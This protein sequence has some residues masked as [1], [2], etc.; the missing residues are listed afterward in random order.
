MSSVRKKL[1]DA[2]QAWWKAHGAAVNMADLAKAAGGPRFIIIAEVNSNFNA[3]G[4]LVLAKAAAQRGTGRLV[5]VDRGGQVQWQIDNLDYPIDFQMLPGDRVLIAEYAGYRVTE[6][7]LKGKVL[8]EIP[9]LPRPPVSVQRLANGNTFVALYHTPVQ[10]GGMLMEYDRAGNIVASIANPANGPG[11][12]GPGGLPVGGFGGGFAS[13]MR[14][15]WLA[16]KMPDGQI[17]C[18]VS[19]DTWYRL[20][21]TG[22][23]IKHFTVPLFGAGVLAVVQVPMVSGNLDVTIK[24]HIVVVQS[25]NTVAEYDLDG[26]LVWK[27][28]ATGNRATR[29]PNGHTLVAS[30]SSGVVELDIAGKTVWQYQPPAGHQT[31]RARQGSEAMAVFFA[32]VPP[33][34]AFPALPVPD[35]LG[36]AKKPSAADAFKRSDI[37]AEVLAKMGS[38]KGD[39]PKELVAVLGKSDGKHLVISLCSL[40]TAVILR[41]AVERKTRRSFSTSRP[42]SCS[43]SFRDLPKPCVPWRSAR[44]ASCWQRRSLARPQQLSLWNTDTGALR[45]SRSWATPIR[46]GAWT[47][48]QTASC[49]LPRASTAPS[50][51]WD[52]AT[53]A[54]VMAPIMHSTN[55]NRVAFSPDGKLLASASGTLNINGEV[56]ISEMATGRVMDRLSWT[57][58]GNSR[59]G[60]ASR[61]QNPGLR[62]A[63]RHHLAVGPANHEIN[64][65]AA[66]QRQESSSGGLASQR[67]VFGVQRPHRRHRF[68]LGHAGP[69]GGTAHDPPVSGQPQ[70][71]RVDSRRDFHARGPPPHRRQSRRHGVGAAAGGDRASAQIRNTAGE[72]SRVSGRFFSAK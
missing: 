6:R 15:Y 5:A 24:G 55:V 72:P 46:C 31:L 47:S 64:P 67:A 30:E 40:R 58:G 62:V 9:N 18:L 71:R 12:V 70:S 42:A 38:G 59:P 60:L 13:Q 25:D 28:N 32:A 22:K 69:Q 41:P 37:P 48:A 36:L 23:E 56:I 2:W 19:N 35:A 50:E 43:R 63:G 17:L 51:F 45:T 57:G 49:W 39:A 10:G 33:A 65:C 21:A 14:W 29:L 20:D 8:W 53:G 66:R 16:Y 4:A 1:G 61:R 52:V 7:D 26:K 34:S 54:A 68:P 44:T 27:V 11:A 3:K